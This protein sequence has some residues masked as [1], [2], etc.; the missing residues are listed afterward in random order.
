MKSYFDLTAKKLI[1]SGHLTSF[2]TV[3]HFKNFS[4]ALILYF[5]NHSPIAVSKDLWGEY[6]D[7]LCS[8]PFF[9]DVF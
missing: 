9:T 5:D 1:K 8:L 4:P 6:S 2:K 3:T 7:I